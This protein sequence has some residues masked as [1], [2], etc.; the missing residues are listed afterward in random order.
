MILKS[1]KYPPKQLQ[2]G[3]LRMSWLNEISDEILEHTLV[4][5]NWIYY[6]I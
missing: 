6:E 2:R 1:V 3:T 4:F 5:L